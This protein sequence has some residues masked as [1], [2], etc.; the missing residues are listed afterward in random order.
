MESG[1]YPTPKRDV[2]V[3][4]IKVIIA[5]PFDGSPIVHVH[6]QVGFSPG[7]AHWNIWWVE[8][9]FGF[10]NFVSPKLNKDRVSNPKP[11]RVVDMD[12]LSPLA[13]DATFS[14]VNP[15]LAMIFG[16]GTEI[17]SNPFHVTTH[18]ELDMLDFDVILGMDCLHSCYASIYYRTRLVTLKVL[19]EPIMFWEG[20]NYALKG[21]NGFV[22]YCDAS[23]I[24]LGCVLM[25]HGKVI[26]YALRQLKMHEKNFLTHDLELAVVVFALKIW[27]HY[28]YGVHD[29]FTNHK[30]L[31]HLFTQKDLNLFQRRL[32]ELLKDCDI[33]VHYH[34][35]K[36]NVVA[37][38]L[39]ELPM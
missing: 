33:S 35:S 28:L 1:V 9:P 12:P 13:K 32:L 8:V 3:K 11:Q 25:K 30:I 16:V 7:L 18:V 31:K 6:R 20:G 38:A 22:V 24:G 21:S 37:D 23:P 14:L 34:S 2:L 39:S 27:R 17:P 4:A 5:D 29:V 26:F 15:Y 19:S 36:S 10:S